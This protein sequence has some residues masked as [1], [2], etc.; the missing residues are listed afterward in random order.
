MLILNKKKIEQSEQILKQKLEWWKRN[1]PHVKFNEYGRTTI[2]TK[3]TK[4]CVDKQY[5]R[6]FLYTKK[7][8]TLSE[9]VV[10]EFEKQLL[11]LYEMDIPQ[12]V[13][14][15]THAIIDGEKTIKLKVGKHTQEIKIIKLIQKIENKILSDII[16]ADEKIS[17][18]EYILKLQNAIKQ[19]QNLDGSPATVENL[20]QLRHKLSDFKQSYK[21]SYH[22]DRAIQEM[23]ECEIKTLSLTI[24][25]LDFLSLAGG[26]S[27]FNSCLSTG[28]ESIPCGDLIVHKKGSYAHPKDIFCLG[29]M[30]NSAIVGIFSKNELTIHG[31][32]LRGFNSRSLIFTDY[33][34]VSI[35]PNYPD[36]E[37]CYNTEQAITKFLNVDVA[38]TEE[39][40]SCS[41]EKNIQD[42]LKILD[43]NNNLFLDNIGIDYK[44]YKYVLKILP[45]NRQNMEYGVNTVRYID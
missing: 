36:G 27:T 44:L 6:V 4:T 41:Q 31:T 34:S 10:E 25:P 7:I 45:Y 17:V 21:F 5:Q 26:V 8:Y 15:I 13:M 1:Y 20:R 32:T 2:T 24:N 42:V 23:A 18:L 22:V 12:L 39:E 19:Q 3:F 38:D 37:E 9:R 29:S 14:K 16:V 11:N 43:D 40:F 28:F 35:A 30:L 33:N